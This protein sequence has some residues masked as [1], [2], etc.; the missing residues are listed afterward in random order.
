MD[1]A[2]R[3]EH[4]QALLKSKKMYLITKRALAI[5]SRCKIKPASMRPSLLGGTKI[6]E[7]PLDVYYPTS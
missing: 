5:Q 1:F 7:A 4:V 6:T 3:F 2:E